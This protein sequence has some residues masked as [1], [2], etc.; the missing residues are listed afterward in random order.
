M[1]E[2]DIAL[3]LARLHV[4]Q[5]ADFVRQLKSLTQ[6][7]IFKP[8]EGEHDIYAAEGNHREDFPM[9]LD[10]ARKAVAH[11]NRVFI[12]PNPK[13]IRTADF[14]FE[15]KG[16]FKM[17]DLKTIHGKASVGNKPK[18]FAENVIEPALCAVKISVRRNNGYPVHRKR[19]YRRFGVKL[20]YCT[21]YRRV[22]G[23]YQLRPQLLG[24][25]YNVVCYVKRRQH[26][27]YPVVGIS[28]HKPAVVIPCLH[29]KGRELI[30]VAVYITN[31]YHLSH[32]L[33][34]IFY[35]FRKAVSC[36]FKP[37]ALCFVT[38]AL[39]HSVCGG[40]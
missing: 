39:K 30:Y 24:V 18:P 35:Y 10:A 2:Y 17:Y 14:I 40:V 16:I 28:H 9:L 6:Y 7:S 21:E 29:I 36:F 1:P 4:L 37:F 33:C 13:G 20:L 15:N 8:V 5:G 27:L 3:E 31:K 11:G 23:N 38:D 26:G 12:L 19:A 34:F 25:G 32:L 22:V